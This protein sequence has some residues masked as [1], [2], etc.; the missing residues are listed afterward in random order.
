MLR[1]RGFTLIELLVG[2]A[3]IAILAAILFPVFAQAREKARA[4]S[5]LSNQKQCGLAMIMYV[6]DYDEDF[7]PPWN[8]NQGAAPQCNGWFDY[9]GPAQWRSWVSLIQPYVKNLQMFHCPSAGNAP[10]IWA[11]IFYNERNISLWPDMGLNYQYLS[12][13]LVDA[14]SGGFPDWCNRTG[15]SQ[16]QIN[17]VA[18]TILFVDSGESYGPNGGVI[19]MVTDPPDG[20]TSPNTLGWGGWGFDGTLGPHGNNKMRH[21]EGANVTMVDGH[22]KHMSTNQ[23]AQ[24]STWNPTKSQTQVVISDFTQYLWDTD[25]RG[26]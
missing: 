14:G 6:Q 26:G 8:M 22:V 17:S 15:K 21:S 2:I 4:A 24:G 3:I 25:D 19:S 9:Y 5:C 16:A 11:G 20:W 18:A 7:A 10:P 13:A 1:R 23:I 12:T